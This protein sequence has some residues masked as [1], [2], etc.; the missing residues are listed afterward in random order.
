VQ[1]LARTAVVTSA[2]A[3]RVKPSFDFGPTVR[4][5]AHLIVH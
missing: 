4:A 3:E 1:T 5:A 2:Q